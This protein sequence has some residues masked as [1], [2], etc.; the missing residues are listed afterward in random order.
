M[1]P[2]ARPVNPMAVSAR[3]ERR[4]TPGQQAP[5]AGSQARGFFIGIFAGFF[6]EQ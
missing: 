5:G 4:V 1:A 2:S 3:K 6:I